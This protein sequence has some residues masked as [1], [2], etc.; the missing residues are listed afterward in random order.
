MLKTGQINTIIMQKYYKCTAR[1]TDIQYV[2]YLKSCYEPGNT[3]MSNFFGMA[4]RF[5]FVVDF[6][7]LKTYNQRC[8][9]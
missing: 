7:S 2:L 3:G 6:F 9:K 1:P 4:S 8:V 5:A